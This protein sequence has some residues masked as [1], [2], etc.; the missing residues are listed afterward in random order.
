MLRH[1]TIHPDFRYRIPNARTKGQNGRSLFIFR[2]GRLVQHVQRDTWRRKCQS[3]STS[4]KE[5]PTDEHKL[6]G[7]YTLRHCLEGFIVFLLRGKDA[8]GS[9]HIRDFRPE[10][11]LGRFA[12]LEPA[13]HCCGCRRG[14]VFHVIAGIDGHRHV[15]EVGAVLG[16]PI[17]MLGDAVL[18]PDIVL[19]KL[20][21]PAGKECLLEKVILGQ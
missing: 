12:P 11:R 15:V 8:E 1:S 17:D 10:L 2:C 3:P 19:D 16:L 21:H 7:G 20:S 13:L 14:L 18:Y 5:R 9:Q 4:A 6:S